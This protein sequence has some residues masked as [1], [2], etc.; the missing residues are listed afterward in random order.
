M[1]KIFFKHRWKTLTLAALL[2]LWYFFCLPAKLFK[3]PKSM[4]LLDRDGQLLGAKI[5]GDGQWRF[6]HSDAVPDKFAS[7]LLEFEDRRFYQHWGIDF[8]GI[9]RALSE[10]WN[11]GKIKSGASTISMQVMRLSRKRTGRSWYQKMLEIILASRL[12]WSYSKKEILA[13]YS[14][15]APFGGNVV[16]LEAAAWRY[17]GKASNNLS[18]GESAT[19][20]VL[21]NSPGLIHPGRNREQLKAK[22]DLLLDLM[23][24]RGKLDSLNCALA[25]QEPLPE[26][27][28]PL[29]SLAPHLLERISM[30]SLAEAKKKGESTLLKTTIDHRL[31]V[32]SA[33]L[34]QKHYR[35]LSKNGIHNLAC[36][37][38]DVNSGEILAYIGNVVDEDL[39]DEHG[40]KV[41]IITARRS[42]GSILKPFLYAF[43]LDEGLLVPPSLIAD[44]PTSING[45]RPQ[46]F[47]T[48]F[49][50]MVPAHRAIERS[51]NVPLVRMLQNY[52]AA[53][54]H[55]RL[56]QLGLQTID[57][58]AKHYGLSLILGGAEAC[59]EDLASA[60]AA[61]ART[62]NH[63]QLNSDCQY[64]YNDFRALHFLPQKESTLQCSPKVPLLSASAIYQTFEAMQVLERPEREGA[65]AYF[66]SARQM[67]WKTGTSFG[68]RDAWAVGLT[69]RYV[70]AVWVGNADGVG[71]PELVGVRAAAPVLFDLLDLLPLEGEAWFEMPRTEMKKMAI[72]KHSG[73]RATSNCEFVDSILVG[74]NARHLP[75]CSF[76][77]VLHLDANGQY[78]VHG[79][80]E[81]P[82]NML[83]Q[84]WFVLP[85]LEESYFKAKNPLYKAVPEFRSDCKMVG[86]SDS[87]M[88]FIYP[89]KETK[90]FLPRDYDGRIST[91]VFKATHRQAKSQIHWHLN[92]EYIGT[93][94]D[95]HQMELQ[96]G[97]GRHRVLLVDERGNRLE[98]Y[99]TILH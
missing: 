28:I 26:D 48:S 91:T 60:Y 57:K 33:A 85:P 40:D 79:D 11:A 31:Q 10:N 18:W 22:R 12:E 55:G 92:Q 2:L 14:S 68:F 4:V 25:K 6:P 58:S 94:T 95:F 36:V 98:R 17:F 39:S 38:A 7:C 56:Q 15:N 30:N 19:L 20:A 61:M 71:R 78:Q 34:L 66:Q 37:I 83:H 24:Q 99:F 45:Y 47:F 53:K 96:P 84:P 42:T 70:I 97:K 27:P 82:A 46:N 5:S 74:K 62:L 59:L 81:M 1:K 89:K 41:D 52:G 93:T 67:A 50:G 49:D 64:Y 63:Y 73:Y 8:W 43:M 75:F 51:L 29:P 35:K 21:P 80:C 72:C 88:D 69:S 87:P 13:L 32:Q 76:H 77:Q 54:F 3:D 44:V 90:I 16:G 9:G 86:D 23:Y 65:W